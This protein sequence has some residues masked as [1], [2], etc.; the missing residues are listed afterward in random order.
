MCYDIFCLDVLQAKWFW[1]G[2]NNKKRTCETTLKITVVTGTEQIQVYQNRINKKE[3]NMLKKK[4][5]YDATKFNF[6][7]ISQ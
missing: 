5:L 2:N 7:L 6:L 1:H 3:G 4:V